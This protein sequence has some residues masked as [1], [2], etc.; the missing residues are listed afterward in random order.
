MIHLRAVEKHLLGQPPAHFPYTVSALQKLNRLEFSSEI[1]FLVGENGSGKSTLLE[2]L[3]CAVGAITI[4]S[5]S[6]D[7]DK[8]LKDIRA[9][10]RKN[11]KL[12]WTKKTKQGFF[13]RSED[14]FGYTKHMNHLR[15][16]LQQEADEIDREFSR[17]GRSN[18]AKSLA[19]GPAHSQLHQ[20]EQ[21]YGTDLDARSHGES[22][23]KL[24]Q[25]R[26]VP[27][28]LYLLDEPEAPL[29][30][31]RQLSLITLL[32]LMVDQHAQFIIATH[33]PILMAYPGAT[34]YSFDGGQ[35]QAVAYDDLE[36]VTVTRSF[37]NNPQQFLRH[38]M[39]PE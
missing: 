25:A 4:G 28:G 10:A 37:L 14:F 35:I 17:D 32:K 34:I 36:H 11:L 12:A 13:M 19:L 6:V 9:F 23:F 22:Y 2:A 27:N 3:A 24:F 26:F 20:M 30:P 21:R 16:S 38:L 15:D 29:S 1:T 7:T 8:T 39:N 31:L 5:E 18:Y 33:S